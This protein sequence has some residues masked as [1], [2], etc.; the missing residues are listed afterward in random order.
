MLVN[1]KQLLDGI[2]NENKAIGAFNV[3]SLENVKA[4][5]QAAEEMQTPIIMQ[6]AQSHEAFIAVEE[7]A[8]IM[9]AYA[10][11]ATVP[12]SV[13]FDH[14]ESVESCKKALDLGF[15]SVMLDA[16]LQPFEENIA[17]TKEVVAY[18]YA[19]NASVEAELGH[20]LTSDVGATEQAKEA[21]KASGKQEYTDPTLAKEF[22]E[23]TGVDSLAISFGTV[24]GVYLQKPTLN[25]D[26]VAD[27]KACIDIPLVMHGGS[28]LQKEEFEQAIHNGIKK[29]N[30]YT[31]MNK[32]GGEA[33]RQ[34]IENKEFIFYDELSVFATQAMKE[35]IKET[36]AIFSGE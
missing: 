31:Y 6:F 16:S 29:I 1:T 3:S 19:K 12:I 36:I 23:R 33:V 14:G 34:F 30:Y 2:K 28:G 10:K 26:I 9:L 7:I 4:V 17:H 18:A 20:M 22:V 24:H 15:T 5:V 32:A 13:H 25:L 35:N 21:S 8:P 11:A 27:V